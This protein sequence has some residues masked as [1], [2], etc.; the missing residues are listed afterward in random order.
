MNQSERSTRWANIRLLR[1]DLRIPI[2]NAVSIHRNRE[3]KAIDARDMSEFA[4]HPC[5]IISNG[6]FSVFAKYGDD[7]NSTAQFQIELDGLRLLSDKA[8]ITT[9]TVIGIVPTEKGALLI[10][11]CLKEIGKQSVHWLHI[12]T[13]LARIHRVKSDRFGFPTNGFLGPL[14]QDNT[15]TVKWS[16]FYG[17]RR[18][19]PHLQL[20][21]K[22][23]NLPSSIASDI[24]GMIPRLA[25][26]CG[27]EVWPSLLH[28]DAQQNN[29]IGTENATYAIDPAVHYGHPE[30]D[31]ALV[32]CWQPASECFLYSYREEMPLDAGFM[33]RRDLWRIPH[34][35]AGVAFEGPCHL[36]RL[37]T[38]VSKY[39]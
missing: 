30:I 19:W 3:W 9:P 22:S 2:E 15:P 20:A 8:G 32:D 33:E 14:N 36:N 16:A 7:P 4:C 1:D 11:E 38:A 6:A 28:G 29:F 10:F 5:A 31:L 21:I 24:E 23:G 37:T 27:P 13:M 12:G 39:L 26:L 35:L 34:Y 17:E 25:E 18:L